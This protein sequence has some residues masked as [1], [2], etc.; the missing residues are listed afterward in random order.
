MPDLLQEGTAGVSRHQAGRR[1][2]DGSVTNTGEV[3]VDLQCCP[4]AAGLA[5]VARQ[6]EQ[7]PGPHRG[8]T[9][10]R[11]S[12]KRLNRAV[13]VPVAELGFLGGVEEAHRRLP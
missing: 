10:Q 2:G 1:A 6:A 9:G 12:S 3:A 7:R 4:E 5:K 11:G 13:E 8:V